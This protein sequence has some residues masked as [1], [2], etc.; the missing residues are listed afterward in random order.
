MSPGVFDGQPAMTGRLAS[1]DG[2]AVNQRTDEQLIGDYTDGDRSALEV[3]IRRYEGELTGFLTRLL[4]NRA[5]AEDA[6]QETFL[7]VHLSA[8]VFDTSRRFKPWLFTIA[9]NKGRDYFRKHGRH[10]AM[11]DLSAPVRGRSNSG[12]GGEGRAFIDLL[13][14]DMSALDSGLAAEELRLGV[15]GAIDSLPHH[16]REILLLAYFQ[17]LSYNRIAES[18]GIP[19][20]TVKSRLHAAVGAFAERFRRAGGEEIR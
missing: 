13:Q 2:L 20:G 3:L 7:Q 17:Q 5:A 15:R 1:A 10:M 14:A 8:T 16:L 18:L 9:A 11:V 4:G 6:F 19:L 12:R